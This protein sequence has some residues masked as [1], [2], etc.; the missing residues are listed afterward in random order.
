MITKANEPIIKRIDG[1]YTLSYNGG[2]YGVNTNDN[3]C[4]FPF[5]EVEAYLKGH[6]EA[7]IPEPVPPAPTQEELDTREIQTLTA[8]LASTDWYATRL[9]ETGKAIPTEIL[10][11]RQS[12]R[13]RIS[14]LKA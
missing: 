10:T 11:S 5:T 13:D 4:L 12:A 14:E 2:R 9:A 8:Y 7:L 6:P 1:S 3:D